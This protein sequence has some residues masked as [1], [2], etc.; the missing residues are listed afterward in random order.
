MTHRRVLLGAGALLVFLGLSSFDVRGSADQ[1]G[2]VAVPPQQPPVRDRLPPPQV[3]RG[4]VRGRVVDGQTGRGIPRARVRLMGGGQ[5]GVRPAV[6]SDDQGTFTFTGLPI[7]A[8]TVS[9]EKSTYMTASYPDRGGSLRSGAA[10]PVM[11]QANQTVDNVV[12]KLYHG[13]VITGRVVDAHGDPV[14]FTQVSAMALTPSGA[15]R[16][17]MRGGSQT[18]DI[19]EF[20]I[21]R[22]PPGRYVLWANSQSR[23]QEPPGQESTPLPQPTPTYFPSVLS[24]SEAQPIAVARGQ[25]VSGIEIAMLEGL[26]TVVTGRV[27]VPDGQPL[28]PATGLAFVNARADDREI[29][30]G[31]IGSTGVRPD[32]TFRFLLAPGN[33]ILEARR[34]QPPGP[35]FAVGGGLREQ[36]GMTK[37][38]VAGETMDVSIVL[39]A[40]ATASGRVVFEGETPPPNPPAQVGVPL[41]SPDGNGTC[42]AGMPQIASDWTFTVDG[43][44]GTCSAP[45]Y[46]QFGRWTIKSIVVNNQDLKSGSIAF[47]PGQHYGNVQ[48]VVT[49]RRNELNLHVT[50]EQGQPTREYAALV[51]PTDKSK[52]EGLSPVVRTFVPPSAD[53]LASMQAIATASGRGN[54]PAQAAREVVSGLMAGEYYAIALDDIETEA[55]RDPAVLERLSTVATKVTLS[56]GAI[57]VNLPR[58]RLNDV[59]R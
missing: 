9:A 32:G 53:S 17:G 52:W 13:G 1:G 31:M 47:E 58:V 55:S 29:F 24:K 48:I 10:R 39:G 50:D 15:G 8:F 35:G 7:G 21:S 43:L 26:P 38:A 22:L 37:V 57:D 28:S 16:G 11:L 27:I 19:G 2:Y 25:T 4:V 18:N 14:E 54:L 56:E 44:V 30:G 45:A 49:D 20:R 36:Y 46:G 59:I 5:P 40:G 12:V 42:R 3:G 41:N 33:Y 6:L 51:F 34:N 23:S